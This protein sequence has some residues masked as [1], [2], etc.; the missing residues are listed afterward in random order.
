MKS[1]FQKMFVASKT[2]GKSGVGLLCGMLVT[3]ALIGS[4]A[5]RYGRGARSRSA[6][7]AIHQQHYNQFQAVSD[8]LPEEM[9]EYEN[10]IA[11]AYGNIDINDVNGVNTAG[12]FFPFPCITALPYRPR[13]G[14]TGPRGDVNP[15]FQTLAPLFN[16]TG[17]GQF[18]GWY[19]ECAVA[20]LQVGQN[21]TPDT[22][23]LSMSMSKAYLG[24]V[25]QYHIDQGWLDPNKKI[26]Y[27]IPGFGV[28]GAQD[29][30]VRDFMKMGGCLVMPGTIDPPLTLDD[31]LF[32]KSGPEFV[33]LWRAIRA[34]QK[35]G[36]LNG[37]TDN[38]RE[39]SPV[40][41]GYIDCGLIG[42]TNP[43][44]MSCFDWMNSPQIS[45]QFTRVLNR[46]NNGLRLRGRRFEIAFNFSGAEKWAKS[47]PPVEVS[48]IN[49]PRNQTAAEIAWN[50]AASN[51][52]SVE[53]QSLV[54]VPELVAL[55]NPVPGFIPFALV[56]NPEFGNINLP[57]G[58]ARATALSFSAIALMYSSYGKVGNT[59]RFISKSTIDAATVRG[60]TG[61]DLVQYSGGNRSYADG[62]LLKVVRGTG[63]DCWPEDTVFMDGAT[64][65][66]IIASRSLDASL[67]LT[68]GVYMQNDAGHAL[69][70]PVEEMAQE[71]CRLVKYYNKIF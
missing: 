36:S 68:T 24:L 34:T 53:F 5:F 37:C 19:K 66:V 14:V 46:L 58:V 23:L 4:V 12:G 48:S 31:L 13:A 28:N 44:G 41:S 55:L 60:W 39:Y 45:G 47:V 2:T 54:I 27:Y 61:H 17:S 30:L 40:E 42:A 50:K 64:K 67:A 71:F 49:G 33:N 15:L 25:L 69:E 6:G 20:D 51:F 1:L 43:L 70:P 32:E 16:R 52:S 57:A 65:G 38:D 29:V 7:E 62:G 22:Y 11:E 18:V 10:A 26:S 59:P 63:L 9:A 3:V 56:A 21:I 8:L 35:S